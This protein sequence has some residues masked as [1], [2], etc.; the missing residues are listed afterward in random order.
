[1]SNAIKKNSAITAE[2]VRL[3]HEQLKKIGTKVVLMRSLYSLVARVR[4]LNKTF[5]LLL[6]VVLWLCYVE[7][8]VGTWAFVFLYVR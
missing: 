6:M 5:K 1:M 2:I 8:A 7:M 4:D 3:R